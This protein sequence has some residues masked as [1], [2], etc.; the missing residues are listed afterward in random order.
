MKYKYGDFYTESTLYMYSI[1]KVIMYNCHL[2]WWSG[3]IQRMLFSM[4]YFE[5]LDLTRTST[6]RSFTPLSKKRLEASKHPL[7]GDSDIFLF[8]SIEGWSKKQ[9]KTSK[10]TSDHQT[11]QS[12]RS[13]QKKSQVNIS[14]KASVT[15]YVYEIR[16]K[17]KGPFDGCYR[18]L[19]RCDTSRWKVAATIRLV[20]HG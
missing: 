14:H 6:E 5:G 13:K 9:D 8:E 10:Q 17:I 12:I 11:N 1:R 20:W 19:T 4:W 3:A 7:N 2:A 15:S 16:P 18:V